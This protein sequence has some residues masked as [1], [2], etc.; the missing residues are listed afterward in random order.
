MERFKIKLTATHNFLYCFSLSF[1][2]HHS[3]AIP[4]TYVTTVENKSKSTYFAFQH[5]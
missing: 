3:S 2:A 5:I 4:Y 1:L